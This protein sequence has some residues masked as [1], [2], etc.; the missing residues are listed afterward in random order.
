MSETRVGRVRIVAI[1]V[2]LVLTLGLLGAREAT[3]GKYTV[4]QCGWHVDAD[5]GWADTTGG[6]VP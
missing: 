1:M 3:A 2:C 4:A 6:L 5:A